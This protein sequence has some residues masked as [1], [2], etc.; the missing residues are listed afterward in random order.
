LILNYLF[1]LAFIPHFRSEEGYNN[2]NNVD[3]TSEGNVETTT[4]NNVED[5]TEL[6]TADITEFSTEGSTESSTDVSV[7]GRIDNKLV[8]LVMEWFEM[9][10]S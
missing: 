10:I 1:I 9:I 2:Q 4:E 3:G 6:T 5:R 7:E 8:L